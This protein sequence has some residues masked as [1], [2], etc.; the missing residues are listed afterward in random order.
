[1]ADIKSYSG[2]INLK[3]FIHLET[4]VKG[5]KGKKV[6]GVF[7]PYEANHIFQSEKGAKYVDID[8]VVRNETDQYGNAGFIKR[9]LPWAIAKEIKEEKR[10]EARNAFETFLG[11]FKDRAAASS[12]SDKPKK[13]K[14][15]KKGKKEKDEDDDLPF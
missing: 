1:M 13:K 2:S 10:K 9:V 3:E 12:S 15:G 5:K 14:K 6:K 8:V 11:N 4:T 7:I